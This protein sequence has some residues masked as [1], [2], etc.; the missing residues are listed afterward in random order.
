MNKLILLLLFVLPPFALASPEALQAA[1]RLLQG[2]H[3]E[4]AP[5][6]SP[7]DPAWARAPEARLKLYPQHSIAP[8]MEA[9][10]TLPV[11]VRILANAGQL[12]IRLTWRDAS[13][14]RVDAHA[15]HRFAD[16]AAVQFPVD[17]A[18]GLPYIG[19]GGPHQPVSLWFW[20]AGGKSERL[21]ANGFGTLA[22][23]PGPVPEVQALRTAEGWRL[24]LRGPLPG[25]ADP[26]VLA[27][28]V[29]DGAE[30]GRDGR[31]HLSPWY[32][33][34]LP[35]LTPDMALYRRLAEEDRTTG[36]AERGRQLV[37]AHGCAG[38]HEL[39]GSGAN[40]LAPSL[41][42]AGGIHWPGYLRRSVADPS[43]FIVPGERY[44]LSEGVSLMPKETWVPESLEDLV[45]YLM[46]LR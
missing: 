12:A 35:G 15:T 28:A 42:L 37:A 9:T 34:R 20:R 6:L 45:A 43:G 17:T 7:D 24:V 19:M 38:C 10:S 16:A 3:T 26:L 36:N 21:A 11:E 30:Q 32:A 27:L 13:E 1:G 44:R 8:G 22:P 25:A 40:A 4:E 39:P 2:V 33:V 46:T 5:P 14:D 29:W 18:A 23:A 41:L 31:K